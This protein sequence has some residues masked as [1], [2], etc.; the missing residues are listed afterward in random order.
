MRRQIFLYPVPSRNVLFFAWLTTV[1]SKITAIADIERLSFSLSAY[2][3]SAYTSSPRP[4]TTPL[5]F[6]EPFFQQQIVDSFG[7]SFLFLRPPSMR[8]QG[9][10]G[11]RIHL[12]L[13]RLGPRAS[14]LKCGYLPVPLLS[15][16]FSPRECEDVPSAGAGVAAGSAAAVSAAAASAAAAAAAAGDSAATV[17]VDATEIGPPGR[18]RWCRG[19]TF[20]TPV[21]AATYFAAGASPPGGN[22]WCRGVAVRTPVAAAANSAAGAS[23]PEGGR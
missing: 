17:A 22:R 19:V 20:R 23:P 13:L 1:H 6:L 5:E 15:V 21:A 3:V 2:S 4:D 18:D 16:R 14:A 12:M 9:V 8:Q 10:R 11:V 7:G